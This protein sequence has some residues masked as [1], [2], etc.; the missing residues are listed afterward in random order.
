MMRPGALRYFLLMLP[1]VSWAAGPAQEIAVGAAV[2]A[3]KVMT[4]A[5]IDGTDE[6]RPKKLSKPSD[7]R[8][9][10][11]P[12]IK[13]Q[14]MPYDPAL[15]VFPYDPNYTYPI[16]TKARRFTHIQLSDGERVIGFYLSDTLRWTSHI[17]PGKPDLFVKPTLEGLDTTGTL[18]TTKR[19]YQ[20]SFK[21]V[22]EE[23]AEAGSWYQ[24]V[25]WAIDEG[26]Y[27]DAAGASINGGAAGRIGPVMPSRISEA[28][29]LTEGTGAERSQPVASGGAG[30]AVQVDKLNFGYSMTGDAPFKPLMVFDDGHFTWIKFPPKLQDI[31]A[32][33]VIGPSGAAEVADF[34]PPRPG[35]DY[36]QI[37]RILPNGA[38]LKLGTDEVRIKNQQE[39]CGGLFQQACR[40]IFN[41]DG[42]R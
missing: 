21:T 34:L 40:P 42:G 26:F 27:E 15:V 3:A 19:R 30:A 28:E 41:V 2:G 39:R 13:P 8:P 35:A 22:D 10:K 6:P 31:P 24:R 37:P 38:L 12:P 5:V 14:A 20:L 29:A 16:L 32:L 1:V 18:I 9:A 11:T 17:P 4:K 33:F 25:S 23:V 36:Y 7:A